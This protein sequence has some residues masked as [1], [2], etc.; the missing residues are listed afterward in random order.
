MEY[1]LSDQEPTFVSVAPKAKWKMPAALGST[2]KLVF[3]GIF[4]PVLVSIT[5]SFYVNTRLLRPR[6]KVQFAWGEVLVAPYRTFP[7]TYVAT[8]VDLWPGI[9]GSIPLDDYNSGKPI[10]NFSG[11]EI[12]A[13]KR[14]SFKSSKD[15]SMDSSSSSRLLKLMLTN[16]GHVTATRI[17]IGFQC[18]EKFGNGRVV[19]SPN[20]KMTQETVS[21]SGVNPP[22]TKI[23]LDRLGA[24]EKA[25]LQLLAIRQMNR[26]IIHVKLRT[27]RST[28]T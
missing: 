27:S 10:T 11:G 25:S 17:K 3:S 15:Y 4:L 12:V 18:P 1:Q 5:V 14:I 23:E 19:A 8:L 7:N 16:E 6:L 24:Y 26:K 21:S 22:L 28:K 2:I 13:A 20:A 9:R